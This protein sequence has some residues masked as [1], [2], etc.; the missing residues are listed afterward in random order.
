MI[1]IYEW[2]KKYKLAGG[3]AIPD[4]KKADSFFKSLEINIAIEIGTAY[5]IS[6]AYIA[7]FVN[8]IYTFDIMTYPCRQLIWDSLSL[9]KKIHSSLI[10]GRP[11]LIDVLKDIPFDFAFIDARHEV[12]EIEKDFNIVKACGRVL[13]HDVDEKRYPDNYEFLQGIGGEIVFNNLGYWEGGK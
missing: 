2:A 8:K 13:F 9:D 10:K 1:N 4:L 5:G 12:E 11:E 3:S 6:T 7:Q